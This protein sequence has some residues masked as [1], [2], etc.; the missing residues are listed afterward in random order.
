[1][2]ISIESIQQENISSWKILYSLAL[3]TYLFAAVGYA[4]A[5]VELCL[6]GRW[7]GTVCYGQTA[8]IDPA[9]AGGFEL[10]GTF[11]ANGWTEVN[12]VPVTPTNQWYVGTAATGFTGNAAYISNNGGVTNTYTNTANSVVH[13][14][15]DVTFPAGE[16]SITLSFSWQVQGELGAWDGVQVSLAPTSVTPASATTTSGTVTGPIVPGATVVGNVLYWTTGTATP[17]QT[18]TVTIPASVSG[19]LFECQHRAPH[20][21]VA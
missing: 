13:F 19:Q 11:A 18:A 21:F 6:G 1:M 14:Y 17:I 2:F 9:G 8:L 7:W 10:G 3:Q 4:L 12:T 15:R 20:L 16:T 5:T